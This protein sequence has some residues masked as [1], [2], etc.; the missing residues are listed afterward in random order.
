MSYTTTL[1]DEAHHDHTPTGWRRWLL[2]VL[3]RL[4]LHTSYC[5]FFHVWEKDYLDEVHRGRRDLCEAL[6]SFLQALGLSRGQIEEV[7]AT[8]QT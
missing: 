2:Q 3:R 5:C 6:R 4:G 7:A 8:C 1:N